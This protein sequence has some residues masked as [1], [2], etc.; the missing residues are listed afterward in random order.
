MRRYYFHLRQGRDLLEDDEG[1]ELPHLSAAR[2]GALRGLQSLLGE[3]IRFGEEPKTDAVIITDE[4]GQQLAAIPMVAVL[5]AL[6][7]KSLFEAS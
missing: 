3:A 7:V 6:I 4:D 5:P 1:V 2:D